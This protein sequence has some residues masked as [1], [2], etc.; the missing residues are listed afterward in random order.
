[1]RDQQEED[2]D[3]VAEAIFAGKEVEELALQQ[4]WS[5]LAAAYA[6]LTRL[7]EDLFVG[8]SPTQAGNGN[9]DQQ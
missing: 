9:C 6:E 2:R 5:L 1:M 8:N 3:P 7:A 4:M